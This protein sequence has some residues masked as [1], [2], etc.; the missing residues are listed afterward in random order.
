MHEQYKSVTARQHSGSS[1]A[2]LCHVHNRTQ[3]IFRAL[4]IATPTV[5]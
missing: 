5:S 1:L 4:P 2:S 3:N